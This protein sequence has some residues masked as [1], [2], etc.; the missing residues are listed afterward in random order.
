MF[1]R[2]DK[3]LAYQRSI[4]SKLRDRNREI[5]KK[6]KN[7]PCLDC[8]Q[9]LPS[10]CMD[11]DH[12]RGE[13]KVTNIGAAIAKWASSPELLIK[14]IAKCDVVCSN[15]HRIRTFTRKKV[16]KVGVWHQKAGAPE[17]KPAPKEKKRKGLPTWDDEEEEDLVPRYQ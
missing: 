14:E 10:Y 13:E 5:V 6:A 8:G 15:C 7:R 12:V 4:S 9:K 17:A 16:K 2:R 3:R 11:F 1:T